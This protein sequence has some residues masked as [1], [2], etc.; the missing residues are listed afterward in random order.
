MYHTCE[1]IIVK[2]NV[3]NDSVL[4]TTYIFKSVLMQDNIQ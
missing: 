3:K 1:E 2:K 4:F